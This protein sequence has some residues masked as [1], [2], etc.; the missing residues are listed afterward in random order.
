VF[1]KGTD[2]TVKRMGVADD[3][4]RF[5]VIPKPTEADFAAAV[6]ENNLYALVNGVFVHFILASDQDS[7][8]KF[9]LSLLS[10]GN[11]GY[12]TRCEMSN[13][14]LWTPK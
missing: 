9:A 5:P 6:W 8:G 4:G 1:V 13:I 12:G 3:S 2:A 7:V 11:G 10:G 14:I